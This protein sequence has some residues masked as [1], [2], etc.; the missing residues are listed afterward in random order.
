MTLPI[1]HTDLYQAVQLVG[2]N[3]EVNNMDLPKIIPDSWHWSGRWLM[4]DRVVAEDEEL[5]I[6]GNS[7]GVVCP[8]CYCNNTIALPLYYQKYKCGSY[9]RD[10]GIIWLSYP[11]RCPS[12]DKFVA[13]TDDES[14]V[15][16]DGCGTEWEV[17]V[18]KRANESEDTG[19]DVEEDDTELEEDDG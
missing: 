8:A 3:E 6:V 2:R 5:D 4:L 18:V 12:C 19:I 13:R 9:C 7:T 17:D 16:C 1:S 11:A 10:C 14:K 15:K